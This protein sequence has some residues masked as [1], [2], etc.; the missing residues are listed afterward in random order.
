LFFL[1]WRLA[2]FASSF[3]VGYGLDLA[4]LYRNL[5]DISVME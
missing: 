3:V 2:S 5:A 4:G 1:A